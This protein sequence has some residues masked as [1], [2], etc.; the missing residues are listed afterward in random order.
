MRLQAQAAYLSEAG[1]ACGRARVASAQVA[2][3]VGVPQEVG[4]GHEGEQGRE[5][6]GQEG[7]GVGHAAW[8]IELD[9]QEHELHDKQAGEEE[10]CDRVV[11]EQ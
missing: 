7:R 11:A 10:A 1:E 3:G 9:G 5:K 4:G 8:G 2:S 6:R